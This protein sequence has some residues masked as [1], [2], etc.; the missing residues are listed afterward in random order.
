M[1]YKTL[2][3]LFIAT[4]LIFGFGITY[5][6]FNTSKTGVLN[7]KLATFI[8]NTEEVDKLNLPILNLNPGEN[9]EYNFSVS[10]TKNSKIS[11]V[12]IEYQIVI[13]TYHLVPLVIELYDSDDTLLLS[14]D[15][16]YSRNE[17]NELVCN[18]EVE[19]LNYQTSSQNNYKL[20]VSFPSEYNDKMYS[21]LVDYIDIEIKSWQKI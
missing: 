13:K 5:S 20:K 11:D 15:E 6:I 19:E 2:L 8:F 7:Q 21:N 3:I 16:N 14:C 4:L 10:N 18:S 1:K 12:T 9:N 17:A